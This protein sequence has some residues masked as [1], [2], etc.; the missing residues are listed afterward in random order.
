MMKDTEVLIVGAGLA[1]LACARYLQ[2]EGIPFQIVEASNSVG[3]RVKTDVVDGFLLDRGFQ[4]LLT[5]YP[6]AQNVLNYSTLKLHEFYPGAIVRVGEHFHQLAD[7]FRE[8]MDALANIFS[9]IGTLTDK[10]RV[11][12]LRRRIV[13]G[14]LDELFQRAERTTLAA[15]RGEGFSASFIET[16]FRPFL[17]G[18]F[19]DPDLNTSS[20]M[21]EFLFR[22]FSLGDTSLPAQGMQAIPEQLYASLP[23]AAVR[24]NTQVQKVTRTTVSLASGEQISADAVVVATDGYTAAPLLDRPVPASHSV[25][26]FYFAVERPPV[27][28]P[29]LVL[30]GNGDGPVN[31]LCVPSMVT[32]SYAPA[33]ADLVSATV[34]RPERYPPARLEADVREQLSKWFGPAVSKWEHLRTYWINRALPEQLSLPATAGLDLPTVIRGLYVCGDHTDTASINGALRSGRLAAQAI[35]DKW[36][37]PLGER[38]KIRTIPITALH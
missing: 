4:V 11:A 24:L 1:G 35:V 17:G 8:P 30:N 3:G 16:F 25:A 6:E 10:L 15:L 7:P 12:K 28:E 19:L 34:L 38:G 22:M 14:K 13:A 21:F 5:A 29:L 33:G 31:N 27:N 23:Q 36:R 37:H 26:C 20:R 9:P 32:R 18:V 2:Q